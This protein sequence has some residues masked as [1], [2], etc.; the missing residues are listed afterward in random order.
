VQPD[1]PLSPATFTHRS[2][3]RFRNQAF[4]PDW[5]DADAPAARVPV[6]RARPADAW[7]RLRTR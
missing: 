1:V 5:L 2:P 3:L 4:S 6:G 7:S